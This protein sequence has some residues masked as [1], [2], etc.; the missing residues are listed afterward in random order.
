MRMALL[1]LFFLAALAPLS[2][3]AQDDNDAAV[4]LLPAPETFGDG[5]TLLVN[6]PTED[7]LPV[8]RAATIGT[9]GGP[10][11]ARVVLNVLL[12]GEGMTA[13]RGSW[14]EVTDYLQEF[15]SRMVLA[16]DDERSQQ[17][18]A[19][20]PPDGCS[21]VRRVEGYE[22]IGGTAFPVGVTLCA[23]DPDILLVATVSGEM[24]GRTGV[25]AS[26]A[27][28]AMTLAAPGATPTP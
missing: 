15:D 28:I 4:A 19:M 27:V 11:G 23:A 1:T 10:A 21:D 24:N 6:D 12:V 20:V 26:D 25:D 7:L 5:W 17:L 2:A 22:S 8:F 18:E 3:A 9:Y 16:V 13:I 14:E